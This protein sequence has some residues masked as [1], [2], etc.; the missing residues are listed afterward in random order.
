MR[1]RDVSECSG[2]VSIPRVSYDD[3]ATTELRDRNFFLKPVPAWRLST[4]IR[5]ER[6]YIRKETLSG[7]RLEDLEAEQKHD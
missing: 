2:Q 6:N 4:R 3:A 1:P 7:E 5:G